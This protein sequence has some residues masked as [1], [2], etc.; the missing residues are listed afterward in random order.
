MSAPRLLLLQTPGTHETRAVLAAAMLHSGDSPI[1]I[2]RRSL[3]E[4]LAATPT[5]EPTLVEQ[6]RAGRALPVGSV[7]FV[8]Q[9]MALAGIPEPENMS[10]PEPLRALLRRDVRMVRAG[11]VL[12]TWF[13]KPVATKAFTGFVFD[14][15]REPKDYPEHV[16]D[17]YWAFLKSDPDCLVWACEPTTFQSEWRFY[18]L[19]GRVAGAARYD[20]DG[21]DGAPEPDVQVVASAIELM[22][23]AGNAGPYALDFGVLADGQTALVEAN[24]AWALG[25]YDGALAPAVY[26]NFLWARWSALK[27]ASPAPAPAHSEQLTRLRAR[28]R[29]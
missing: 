22:G 9:A 11:D 27:G 6:L 20:P 26:A 12:G 18:V 19:D 10:Y 23:G 16:R 28:L 15:M 7:E 2:S 21:A 24:D 8:R 25:L 14:T 1:D 3:E 5:T 4:L 29:A 13:V 17:D